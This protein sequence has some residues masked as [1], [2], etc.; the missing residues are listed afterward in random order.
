MVMKLFSIYFLII[1]PTFI[2]LT[3]IQAI[4]EINQQI[5]SYVEGVMGTQVD[6][7]ECWDLANRA[8]LLVN[9][10]WD[11]LY[12]Y[13]K[14]IDYKKDVVF[15]GDII[16]FIDTEIEQ[17]IGFSTVTEKLDQHTAII[18]RVYGEGIYELAHQNTSFS[19]KKVVTSPIDLNGLIKGRVT[20][21][22]PVR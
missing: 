15:P 7:G 5:V 4:P 17:T 16:H 13:G 18:L 10:K 21:Y 11:G 12:L 19:G 2:Q 1:L 9:A 3:K 20:I 6:R 22:R 14:S 8:L